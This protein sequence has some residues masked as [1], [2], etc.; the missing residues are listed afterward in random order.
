MDH[1]TVA[2]LRS[3]RRA[4]SV[5]SRHC[6]LTRVGQRWL[7]EDLGWIN[8]TFVDRRRLVPGQPF[9]ITPQNRVM[10]SGQSAMP[11]PMEVTA[12]LHETVIQ[13]H[14]GTNLDDNKQ[15]GII[16]I[17]ACAG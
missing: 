7:L 16:R 11:W 12:P 1:W 15:L 5:S 17:W 3:G 8:G 10:L 2:R 4:G 6:R 9:A 14:H 13:A